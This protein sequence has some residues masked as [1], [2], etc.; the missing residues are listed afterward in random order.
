MIAGAAAIRLPHFP[1]PL[2]PVTSIRFESRDIMICSR[3]R[4][5]PAELFGN[6]EYHYDHSPTYTHLKASAEAGCPSCVLIRQSFDMR[7]IPDRESHFDT[8]DSAPV[9]L[10][11]YAEISKGLP[12]S[13]KAGGRFGSFQAWSDEGLAIG[14]PCALAPAP[15]NPGTFHAVRQCIA[16][17][18]E[19][20]PGCPKPTSSGFLPTRLLDVGLADGSTAPRVRPGEECRQFGGQYL[21]L[22]YC[23]GSTLPL[24]TTRGNL[25]Q[26]TEGIAW[27]GL[28]RTLQD[29]V[30]ITRSLGVRH[31]WIDALCIIQDDEKDWQREAA[32]MGRVYSHSLCTV[33]ALSSRDCHQGIFQSRNSL[34]LT[35]VPLALRRDDG[36]RVDVTLYP[37]F[38]LWDQ[39]NK[40]S[41]LAQRG[42]T[43]QESELS[44][45][46]LFFSTH[47]TV[48]QCLSSQWTENMLRDNPDKLDIELNKPNKP[49]LLK[50]AG[51]QHLSRPYDLWEKMI[52]SFSRRQFTCITD[53]LV[54]ISG[55]A[56]LVQTQTGDTYVAGLWRK[57]LLHGLLWTWSGETKPQR[58]TAQYV[59]PSWSWLSVESA[60]FFDGDI[61]TRLRETPDSRE[62]RY[63]PDIVEVHMELK[64]EDPF[65]QLTGGCITLRGWMKQ[66]ECRDGGDVYDADRS[67]HKDSIGSVHFDVEADAREHRFVHMLCLCDF[68]ELGKGGANDA[69]GI[70]LVRVDGPGDVYRRV[71]YARWINPDW[72]GDVAPREI[73]II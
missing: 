60:V 21:T 2:P 73:T 69:S 64:G 54:A 39:L 5:M 71:A 59:A 14:T 8:D 49:W 35:P 38:P 27:D 55:L 57:D 28:P 32:T 13:S 43:L 29:A 12:L 37:A 1:A 65:G 45:R 66:G 44:S 30:W 50:D 19:T 40:N 11:R 62:R 33:A 6:S 41:P 52:Y 67:M 70:G 56:S 46:M 16:T 22:S 4:D 25:H 3:C 68:V 72:L 23:W 63:G 24:R 15:D 58:R 61:Y 10:S 51:R 48:W 7:V 42:W 53:R 47:Q 31:I 26:M 34:E 17:C 9:T 36:G 18:L 20:H